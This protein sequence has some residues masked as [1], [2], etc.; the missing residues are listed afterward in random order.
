MANQFVAKNGL[1]SQNNSIVTGSLTVTNGITGSL[2][3][4]ASQAL[5]ASYSPNYIPSSDANLF[6]TKMSNTFV[7]AQ[8]ITGSILATA[9]FSLGINNLVRSIN[10][11]FVAGNSNAV[12]F[13]GY[14]YTGA[15]AG[16]IIF[17]VASDISAEIGE[18]VYIITQ[19]AAPDGIYKVAST[20]YDDSSLPAILT[21]TLEDTSVS[22][23]GQ[24]ASLL[25]PSLTGGSA[26]LV[27][28]YA[29]AEGQY[30]IAYGTGSHAEGYRTVT[31]GSNSH[32]AGNYSITNGTAQYVI[33]TYNKIV[34]DP[35]AF[36][37]GNGT[38]SNNRSNLIFASGSQVQITGSL[39]VSGS[40][41]FTNIGPAIFSGSV[42]ST[43][44]FTGSF[45]GSLVGYV[46]N[47]A[48]SSFV[49]SNQTGSF[50]LTSSFNNFTSSVVTTSSFNNY[51]SSVATT[52]SFNNYTSSVTSQF[53]GT[54]SFASTASFVR[55][56]QTASYVTS[57]NVVGTVLSASYALTASYALSGGS[58]G[59]GAGFPYS[60]S[61][62][63]TG[64][65]LVSGSG[66][67]ITGSLNV[68]G[69]ITGSLQ[70]T[71]SYTT[72]FDDYDY[73]L[74]T[75]FRTSYNY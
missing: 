24:L 57:S 18:Y 62:V 64:S 8:T 73:F 50:T 53:A 49:I 41:T 52:S 71:S 44:G 5:T 75:S 48:T 19:G 9:D 47:T 15:S 29:H 11:S 61:A 33:G 67:V 3:G 30:T 23:N 63:I 43:A 21:I 6:A 20:V 66:V 10:S 70:G 25:T 22:G 51:T 39:V 42:T 45:S 2:F 68:S 74:V 16:V 28:E 40:S 65:L 26:N 55:T 1:I 37:V 7:G 36:V 34:N 58:G 35:Y 4:T 32:A 54:A 38:D 31:L 46:A 56:A 59:S 60:G 14:S 69:G 17:E 27:T 12:G 13:A 72:D